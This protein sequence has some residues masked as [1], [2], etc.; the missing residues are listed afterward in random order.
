MIWFYD[1]RPDESARYVHTVGKLS[2]I[3]P[4]SL[5]QNIQHTYTHAYS[6]I[7]RS[8]NSEQIVFKYNFDL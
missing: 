6:D 8:L 1:E 2:D 7:Y 5:V 4:F 3:W